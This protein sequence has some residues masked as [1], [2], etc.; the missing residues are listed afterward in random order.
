[1]N[2]EYDAF[3]FLASLPARMKICKVKANFD[4]FS[5]NKDLKGTRKSMQ[6]HIAHLPKYLPIQPI[7]NG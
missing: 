2:I 7:C 5:Q 3:F 4:F 1:M 6:Y